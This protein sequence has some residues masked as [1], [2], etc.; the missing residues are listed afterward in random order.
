MSPLVKV[1]ASFGAH[2]RQ[3]ADD[4]YHYI[5]ASK[6]TWTV[7]IRIIEQCTNALYNWL[8]HNGLALD[9][10]KCEAIQFSCI[11]ARYTKDV[12]NIN[13]T[14]VSIALSPSIKSL[15]VILDLH[16]T[17]NDHVA[18]V[19]KACYF[20]IRALQHIRTSLPDD[21]TKMI[22]SSII[23]SRLEYCNSLLI[24]ISET[25][26]S[27]F[28]LIENILASVVMGTGSHPYYICSLK[29][30]QAAGQTASILRT[31]V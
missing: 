2:H 23:R 4:T 28:Q 10:S 5:F 15:V 25:N 21:I 27:K 1:T 13:V 12:S 24:D 26:F 11:P 16:L 31:R 20:H 22:A 8:S 14:G 9:T 7:S 19:S 30:T 29:A 3:Y 18:T 6:E 17:F